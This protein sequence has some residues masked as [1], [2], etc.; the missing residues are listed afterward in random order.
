MSS[1]HNGRIEHIGVLSSDIQ[2]DP[3]YLYLSNTGYILRTG[4]A[5]VPS[6][7]ADSCL[8]FEKVWNFPPL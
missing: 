7:P 6:G 8:D 3:M 4:R 5:T 1:I 2:L